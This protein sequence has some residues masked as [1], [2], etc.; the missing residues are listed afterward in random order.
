[1][2]QKRET[3][4]RTASRRL[5]TVQLDCYAYTTPDSQQHWEVS[6]VLPPD[7]RD[8][9][10]V[11]GGG[12]WVQGNET[13][14]GALLTCSC[15]TRDLDGWVVAS[16]DHLDKDPHRLSVYLL[17]LRID[18]MR[19]DDLRW[20]VQTFEAKSARQEHPT[21]EVSVPE[22]Y[23][24]LSGGF[25]VDWHGEGNLA[26]ASFPNAAQNGWIAKSKSHIKPDAATITAYAVGIKKI[27]PRPLR[28]VGRAIA[29]ADTSKAAHP[30]MEVPLR[31]EY[32][33]TGAGAEV[34]W[35]AYGNMLTRLQPIVDDTTTP[36]VQKVSASAKDHIESDPSGLKVYAVGA[37]L[38]DGPFN[39]E[40]L[41]T[42]VQLL[43]KVERLLGAGV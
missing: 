6:A 17:A 24:M 28:R 14:A 29:I 16:K 39:A 33:L 11:V 15:P 35:T 31:L 22:D 13:S 18:G 32:L 9:A 1:M 38:D 8:G 10:V 21:A 2:A 42:Y 12:G 19:R 5:S 26:T 4:T 25:W 34:Q 36:V 20:L 7:A 40:N 3:A 27:L 37:R 43:A 41:A 23:L 30:T